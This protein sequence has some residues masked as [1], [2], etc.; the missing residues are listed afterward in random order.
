[1]FWLQVLLQEPPDDPF[2]MSR[3][4]KDTH[5]KIVGLYYRNKLVR[6][7]NLVTSQSNWAYFLSHLMNSWSLFEFQFTTTP[8][9]IIAAD[10][11][12]QPNYRLRPFQSLSIFG[13]LA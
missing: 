3:P 2:L 12:M 4:I 1:M 13:G 11:F 9:H 6:L 7:T 5:T 10:L 8:I